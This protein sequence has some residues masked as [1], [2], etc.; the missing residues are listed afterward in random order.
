MKEYIGVNTKKRKLA[1]NSFEK[2][3]FKLMNNSVYGETLQ[4]VRKRQNIKLRTS[5]K[6]INRD[7][8]NLQFINRK[9]FDENLVAVQMIKETINRYMSD[10]YK[11][12]DICQIFCLELSK[13]LMYDFHYGLIKAKYGNDARLLF[14]DTDS[15]CYEIKTKDFYQDMYD[16][17]SFFDLSDM[18]GKL[19]DN[20][21]KKSSRKV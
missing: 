21:N 2:D 6:L 7:I 19:N 18:K 16:N 4:D 10:R 12:I 8:S 14:M 5:D 1:K 17:K 9:I 20:T 3:F 13:E 15:L 11:Q